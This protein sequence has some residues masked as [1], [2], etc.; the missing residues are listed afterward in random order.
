MK[1][2]KLSLAI[3]S[4]YLLSTPALATNGMNMEGYGPVSQAM[5]GT[6]QAL[7]NGLGGMMNNPATMGMGRVKG[8]RFQIGVGELG[9]DVSVKHSQFGI[10]QDSDGSSYYMPGFGYATKSDGFT[11][12][13]GILG[14]GGMGTE[15]GSATAQ[16]DLFAGGLSMMGSPTALS[17]RENRSE[18]SVGRILL[19]MNMEINDQ[20]TIGGS[21]DYVW[22]GLDIM[23]DMSGAQFGALSQSG[24]VSGTMASGLNQM[25]QGGLVSDVHWARFD[26]SDDSDYTGQAKG[27]GFGGKLGFTYQV[28]NKLS[29]GGS[30]HTQTSLSD[31]SGDATLSMGVTGDTGYFTTGTPNGTQ[32]ALPAMDISGKIKVKDFEWPSTVAI[33]MAYNHNDWLFTADYKRI[34]WSSVMDKFNMV[35]TADNVATNGSFAGANIDVTLPQDWSDQNIMMVGTAYKLNKKLIVRAG[36]NMANN[37]VPDDMVNPL[38]PATVEKHYTAGLGYTLAKGQNVDFS[39][40]HAPATTVTGDGDLNDGLEISHGQTNWQVM[41][42][43]SWGGQLKPNTNK[44]H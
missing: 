23:M 29:I 11:W 34:N 38:F 1:K 31:L 4:A 12:G 41:Y 40:V 42:S 25:V 44:F 27:T 26:F 3:A 9:P 16:T 36:L 20:L 43:Y 39:V 14:Q 7:N 22:A 17:G 35:F 5:G 10:D 19:P 30:Y 15:Y 2:T 6:A 24:N 33:G 13:V 37:P 8:N 28:N 32:A 21:I 18:L